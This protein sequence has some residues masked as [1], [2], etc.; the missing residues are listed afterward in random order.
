MVISSMLVSP[1]MADSYEATTESQNHLKRISQLLNIAKDLPGF[2]SRAPRVQTSTTP[3]HMQRDGPGALSN[4]QPRH[5]NDFED[6]RDIRIMPTFEEIMSPHAEYRPLADSSTWH[7]QGMTGLLDRQFRLLREDTIGQLRD[8]VR[9]ELQALTKAC[10]LPAGTAS[11]ST[12]AARTFHYRGVRVDDITFDAFK[13]LEIS[14]SFKQPH[15]ASRHESLRKRAQWWTESQRLSGDALVCLVSVPGSIFF[16]TVASTGNLRPSATDEEKARFEERSAGLFKARDFA[17]ITVNP[18]TNEASAVG[19]LVSGLVGS[20]RIVGQTISLVEF[21][22]VMLPSFYPTLVALQKMSSSLD[23]PFSDIL[24]PLDVS[25]RAANG[26]HRMLIGPPSYASSKLFHFDLSSVSAVDQAVDVSFTPHAF[27]NSEIDK[28]CSASSLDRSQA[29]ALIQSLAREIALIQ[30]PPGTGKSYTGMALIKVLL[31]HKSSAKLGPILCVCYT[32]HALDQLLEHLYDQGITQIARIGSRSKSDK[33]QDRTLQS[34]R[35]K[36]DETRAENT[37]KRKLT[38]QLHTQ[39]EPIKSALSQIQQAGSAISIRNYLSQVEPEHGIEL[40]NHADSEGYQLAGSHNPGKLLNQWMQG[41]QKGPALQPRSI[42]QLQDITLQS[43]AHDERMILYNYWVRDILE[44]GLAPLRHRITAYNRTREEHAKVRQEM[45]MR[46]LKQADIIGVTTSGL[47]RNLDLLSKVPTKVLLCEEAGE[48]LE[49]HLL[50]ALLPSIEHAILIGDH[51]QL[52]PQVQNHEFKTEH[53]NGERFALDKSLFERLVQPSTQTSCVPYQTLST[54]RRMHPSISELVR[55]TL[56]PSLEDYNVDYPEVVGMKKRLFWFNHGNH[57]KGRDINDASTSH[58]NDYEVEM[59][60]GLVSHLT[61]QGVYRSGQIAVLTPYLG[62]MR[63]IRVRLSTMFEVVTN[64]RDVDD[65]EGAGLETNGD[66][67]RQ[68]G[69]VAKATLSGTIRIATVDNFQ[70]EEA[71]IVIISLV[72]SN[73]QQKCGFLVTSNRINVLLSRAKHGMYIFGDT[74][75]VQH[76]PMWTQVLNILDGNDCIGDKLEI[77]CPRHPDTTIQ[78]R[79]PD[80]FVRLAPEGGCQLKCTSRLPCGHTC[81]KSCHSDLLHNSTHCL[82]PCTRRLECQHLCPKPCGD[83]CPQ[84]CTVMLSD[85]MV[86]LPCG[87]VKTELPCYQEQDHSR[88]RCKTSVDKMVSACGHVVQVSCHVDVSAGVFHCPAPCGSVLQ[89]GHECISICND[90]KTT[91]AGVVTAEAHPECKRVCGRDHTSCSHS[92]AQKCHGEKPC[93][94]CQAICEVRCSHSFCKKK[95]HEPCSPCA[96]PHCPSG[97]AHRRCTMPCA[98]PCD[99][100]PCMARCEA[101]LECGHRWY[102]YFS[103]SRH[104]TY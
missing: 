35:E 30:G 91:K 65:L 51:Q 89:C 69:P 72:R 63:S 60:A 15:A 5:N 19:D 61:K 22:G 90:C 104:S 45:D 12:Q 10:N 102:V 84:L 62:Q 29:A 37:E 38:Y 4:G 103:S 79:G 92:C 59:I 85:L 28:L 18:V 66:E 70:G 20:R 7:K 88:I 96:E 78:V 50:T 13:G 74:T 77:V 71:E 97:C 100:L 32:N 27:T 58:T 36:Q 82:E 53:K 34:L 1:I 49:A 55:S 95:C 24:A 8:S 39:A 6:I 9:A 44:D 94:P 73:D 52:R 83:L 2:A 3:F 14:L 47:A 93:P 40:F 54:Q 16:C 81:T 98:A 48:V 87:H 25:M 43:M 57:E 41:G 26:G 75:C 101:M 99:Y 21:P 86:E 80:D 64:D 76:V 23:V 56:Y 17:R 67:L 11:S 31:E 68:Q 46:I 33:L 42:A